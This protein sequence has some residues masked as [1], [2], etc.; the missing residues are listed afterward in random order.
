[1]PI[2]KYFQTFPI[3]TYSNTQAVDIT[4]RAAVLERV[5]TDPYLYY[6]YTITDNERADQLAS[7]YYEDSFKSWI[8]YLSNKITDP[9]YEWYLHSK[10]FDDFLV[11]KYGSLVNSYDKTSFYR[12]NWINSENITISA[13]NALTARLRLFWEPV[14]GNG[15]N[16]VA[17]SRKQ[18]NWIVN[19]NKI[20]K[21]AVSNTSFNIDEIVNINFNANNT[22]T[23]QVLKLF[24]NCIYVQHT[25]GVTV[26]NSTV[27][28]TVNS[29]IYGRE[30]TI[31]TSFS[32]TTLITETITDEE[33]IYWS[34]VTYWEYEN[35]KNEFNKTIRVI[36]NRFTI[37][38]VK[39]LKNIMKE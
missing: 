38:I 21:Y 6:S 10:E 17:Y 7:R 27:T 9:Y 15:N 13:F 16:I 23:A 12:N 11:N 14:Y 22:G 20:V 34:P 18:K 33:E 24:S 28:I 31:N 29:Y 32:N 39:E 26:S 3:I 19:T 8:V 4:K 1:M 25:T 30:S 2:D 5:S 36:D 35:E 37:D